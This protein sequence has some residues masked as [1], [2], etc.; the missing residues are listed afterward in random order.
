MTSAYTHAPVSEVAILAH[1]HEDMLECLSGI[2]RNHELGTPGITAEI[3][4]RSKSPHGIGRIMSAMVERC[5]VRLESAQ[6][7]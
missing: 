7:T 3:P 5:P 4:Y 1:G 6:R 2:F